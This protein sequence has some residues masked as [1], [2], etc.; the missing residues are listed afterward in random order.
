MSYG[1]RA[2]LPLPPNA[3]VRRIYEVTLLRLPPRPEDSTSGVFLGLLSEP[4]LSRRGSLDALE[5]FDPR[6]LIL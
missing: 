3:G 5:S 6:T 2:Y 1:R 4:A